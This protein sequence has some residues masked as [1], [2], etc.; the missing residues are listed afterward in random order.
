MALKELATTSDD[1]GSVPGAYMQRREL[2][3]QVV[4]CLSQ[5]CHGPRVPPLQN[6]YM[7]ENLKEILYFL[8]L[9][10]I[11]FFAHFDVIS[12]MWTKR[13]DYTHLLNP[14]SCS[15][16][17]ATH[18]PPLIYLPSPCPSSLIETKRMLTNLGLILLCSCVGQRGGS[19]WMQWPSHSRSTAF[20]SPP[21]HHRLGFH[22]VSH[23]PF[24]D[25]AWALRE[26][27]G[28]DAPFRSKSSAVSRSQPL[29]QVWVPELFRP[30]TSLTSIDCSTN[31]HE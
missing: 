17:A 29:D 6:K 28:T 25:L 18:L 30:L 8:L 23:T 22:S 4:L 11:E 10:F 20:H 12:Y 26:G 14:P 13:L 31:L 7:S 5:A 2:T 15:S 19:S 3:R 1:L 21:S 9:F 24:C 27:V 16:Q